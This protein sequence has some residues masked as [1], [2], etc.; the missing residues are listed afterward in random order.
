MNIFVFFFTNNLVYGKGLE[1]NLSD[2]DMSNSE[3]IDIN[4]TTRTTDL[5][6][7]SCDVD[8]D[9]EDPATDVSDAD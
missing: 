3:L 9:E 8:D 1:D 5:D 6:S 4:Q 2:Y 7:D